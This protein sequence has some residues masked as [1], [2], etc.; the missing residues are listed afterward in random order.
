MDDHVGGGESGAQRFFD[1]FADHM[2]LTQ[3]DIGIHRD[4]DLD[5]FRQSCRPGPK[6]MHPSDPRLGEADAFDLQALIVGKFL[7]HQLIIGGNADFPGA[8]PLPGAPRSGALALPKRVS[9]PS[10]RAFLG[11]KV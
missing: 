5:E 2:G 7:I 1:P 3:A 4:M 6:I 8:P 11:N 10:V 9:G